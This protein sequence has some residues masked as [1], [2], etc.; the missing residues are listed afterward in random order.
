MRIVFKENFCLTVESLSGID[1]FWGTWIN[2][3]A[4][5]IN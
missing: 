1:F 5:H 4:L 3:D 2:W